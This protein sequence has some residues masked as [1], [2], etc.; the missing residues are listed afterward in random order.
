[1]F[2]LKDG[3]KL[4]LQTFETMKLFGS[5][6]KLIDET[7]NGENVPNIEVVKAVLV[8]CNLVD[9]PNQEESEVLYTLTPTKSCAYL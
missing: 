1:M 7:E 9:N 4:E 3:Y 8:Q 2:K 5:T 6:K